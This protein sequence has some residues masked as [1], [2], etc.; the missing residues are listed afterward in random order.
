MSH[1]SY[2]QY[3]KSKVRQKDTVSQGVII[4]NIKVLTYI[5]LRSRVHKYETQGRRDTVHLYSL[6]HLGIPLEHR[7]A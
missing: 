2:V 3:L 4:K 6:T 1:Y 7:L 5:G